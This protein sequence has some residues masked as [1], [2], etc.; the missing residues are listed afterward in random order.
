MGYISVG[1]NQLHY[2]IWGA[3]KRLAL[4]F[5]GY[6]ND[7]GMFFPIQEYTS[8]DFTMLSFDLP[9]HGGSHWTN[10]T[11]LTLQQ[12]TDLTKQLIQQYGVAKISLLGYSLGGRICLTIATSMPQCIDKIV[13]L[14]TDGLTINGYYLFLTRTWLGRA[15]FRHLLTYPGPYFA[16]ADMLERAKLLHPSRNAFVK[17]ALRTP[18]KRTMLLQVWP[19]LSGLLPSPRQIKHTIAQYK[20]QV[21]I[22][23]GAQ[24]KIMPPGIARRFIY[25][26]DSAS[27]IILEK[28]HK[29]FDNETAQPI[30]AQLI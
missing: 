10:D 27:L 26:L 13:L 2:Q 11:P 29:I 4:A 5:H 28:G 20:I 3:G 21:C 1:N 12:L 8:A 15:V 19:C 24:D 6:G 16:I 7:A 23:M 17:K 14:A 30:A 25:G 18:E 22:F 9:H